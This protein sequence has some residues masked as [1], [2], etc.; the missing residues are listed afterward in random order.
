[1]KGTLA[2]LSLTSKPHD[3]Y[4]THDAR[5][6][7]HTPTPFIHPRKRKSEKGQLFGHNTLPKLPFPKTLRRLKS[8]IWWIFCSILLTSLPAMLEVRWGRGGEIASQRASYTPTS[9]SSLSSSFLEVGELLPFDPPGFCSWLILRFLM[10][11]W[12]RQ[13]KPS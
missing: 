10:S 7:I 5:T 1:M 13:R 12:Q 4:A 3:L 6:T 11:S 8:S 2:C 9:S